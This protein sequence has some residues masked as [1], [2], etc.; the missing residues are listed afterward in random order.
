MRITSRDKTELKGEGIV[1]EAILED[2]R[3]AFIIMHLGKNKLQS[4]CKI[5]ANGD[6]IRL[7]IYRRKRY[8]TR[9]QTELRTSSGENMLS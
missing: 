3:N 9:I 7:V 6:W 1:P 5:I 2:G 8:F 4:V